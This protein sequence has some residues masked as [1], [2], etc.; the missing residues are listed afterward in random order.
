MFGTVISTIFLILFIL[1][2]DVYYPGAKFGKGWN[3]K[4]DI[5]GK[6]FRIDINWS[7]FRK[8]N[9]FKNNFLFVLLEIG[10]G[11]KAVSVGST[12][13]FLI[14]KITLINCCAFDS[15]KIETDRFVSASIE[16]VIFGVEPAKTL[17]KIVGVKKLIVSVETNG[18]EVSS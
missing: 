1:I 4:I 11:E 7:N 2:K 18:S 13:D 12:I 17:F 8:N 16:L 9:G 5:F 14:K 10:T 3:I 15:W 6:S